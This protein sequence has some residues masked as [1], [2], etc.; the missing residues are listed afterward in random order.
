VPSLHHGIV[1]V[2]DI[3]TKS[4]QS[5]KKLSVTTSLSS[6]QVKVVEQE[7]HGE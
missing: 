5:K 4:N 7:V 3:E 6:D 2:A 1:T